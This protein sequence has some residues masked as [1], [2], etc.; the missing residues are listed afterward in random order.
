M[1]NLPEHS[2]ASSR[3]SWEWRFACSTA[4][5]V[6][7]EGRAMGG[8]WWATGRGRAGSNELRCGGHQ[9]QCGRPQQEA[10]KGE[11]SPMVDGRRAGVDHVDEGKGD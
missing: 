10:R 5:K 2:R 7:V 9:G 11:A 3:R 6:A 4:V 8:A 1:A